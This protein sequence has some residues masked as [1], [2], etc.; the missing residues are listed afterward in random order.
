[1][2]I[3]FSTRNPAR[4]AIADDARKTITVPTARGTRLRSR[5]STAGPKTAAM[6]PAVITGSTIVCVSASSQTTPTSAAATP[7]R[8][9]QAIPRFR[10]HCGAWNRPLSSPGSTSM[11]SGL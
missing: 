11:Y 2:L 3:P 8:S 6:I 5:R 10:S 1:M 4:A 9:Q 7:N